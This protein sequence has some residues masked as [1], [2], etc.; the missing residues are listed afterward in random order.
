MSGFTHSMLFATLADAFLPFLVDAAVKACVIFLLASSTVI[1]L[2]RSSA[3]TRHLVWAVALLAFLLLPILSSTVPKWRVLPGWL[4][5]GNVMSR[6]EELGTRSRYQ[7]IAANEVDVGPR[8]L[9]QRPGTT[10]A[11]FELDSTNSHVVPLPEPSST[12]GWS[13]NLTLSTR[14]VFVVWLVGFGLLIL[15]IG[16]SR[17]ILRHVLLAAD[18]VRDGP[19]G[20]EIRGAGRQLGIRRPVNVYLSSRR[21]TP[22]TW[23]LLRTDLLLPAERGAGD[24]GDC[25]AWCCTSLRMRNMAIPSF[26]S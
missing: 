26:M 17:I 13:W 9:S 14:F 10:P 3:A 22:M 15:R 16:C 24:N 19:L 11:T 7:S 6:T 20:D 8:D 23:G 2:S 18:P 12:T 4:G 25:A 5:A 21:A 1:L